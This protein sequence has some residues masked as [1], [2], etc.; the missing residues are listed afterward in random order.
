LNEVRAL[1]EERTSGQAVLDLA[2]GIRGG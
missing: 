2:D 1:N